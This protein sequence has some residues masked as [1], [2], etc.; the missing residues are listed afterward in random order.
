MPTQS[1]V[2]LCAPVFTI[3]LQARGSY[4]YFTNGWNWEKLNL[5]KATQLVT[6]RTWIHSLV[7]QSPNPVLNYPN[8]L[9]L[10]G[11]IKEHYS[12]KSTL[13]TETSQNGLVIC[14]PLSAWETWKA[15]FNLF[16][17]ILEFCLYLNFTWADLINNIKGQTA[18]D[19]SMYSQEFRA[20]KC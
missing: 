12:C 13:W 6:G 7:Y 15:S 3:T 2:Y 17:L 5:F 1:D 9:T 19:S 18:K 4:L 11:K 20:T 10:L 8:D 16:H 14:L